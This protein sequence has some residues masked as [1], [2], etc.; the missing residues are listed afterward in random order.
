MKPLSLRHR[1]ELAIALALPAIAFVLAIVTPAFFARGNLTDMFLA[2][3]PVLIAALGMTL[4][5]LTGHIDISV[6]SVF[7]VCGGTGSCS[8]RG[9]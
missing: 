5:I 4:I 7:A 1:A 9:C 8:G 2:N 6:G 3:M